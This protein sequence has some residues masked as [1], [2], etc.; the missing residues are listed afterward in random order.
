MFARAQGVPGR[1]HIAAVLL[2]RNP[3]RF[4]TMQQLFDEYTSRLFSAR[5]DVA[6][7]LANMASIR[8]EVRAM[9]QTIPTLK[10]LVQTY[11]RALLEGNADVLTYYNAWDNLISRE[12]DLLNLQL[13]L[14]DQKIALEIASGT[15]LGDGS[16][17]K[18]VTQ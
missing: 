7:L 8:Q 2:E 4:E 3:G 18:A 16:D 11:R 6:K 12:L 9:E 15:Y 14:A 10:N 1:P 13:N 5:A 17:S